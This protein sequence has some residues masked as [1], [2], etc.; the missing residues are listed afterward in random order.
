MNKESNNRNPDKLAVLTETLK[1]LCDLLPHVNDTEGEI[2]AKSIAKVI[3][4]ITNY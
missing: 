3:D 2:I 1:L 4:S